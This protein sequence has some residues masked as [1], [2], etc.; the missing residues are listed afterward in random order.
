[1]GIFKEEEVEE[2]DLANGGNVAEELAEVRDYALDVLVA[3]NEAVA[4]G[5]GHVADNVE[6]VVLQPAREVADGA[7]GGVELVGLGEEEGRGAVDEGLTG[8]EGLVRGGEQAR[9]AMASR[10]GLL[11]RVELALDEALVEAIDVF[12]GSGVGEAEIVGPE[13]HHVAVLLVQADMRNL[14]AAL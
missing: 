5:V 2:G 6:G 10:H 14:G 13:T 12:D 8:V 3:L 11:D 1:E 7:G 9:E 4:L